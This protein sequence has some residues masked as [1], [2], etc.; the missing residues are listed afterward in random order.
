MVRVLYILILALY[1]LIIAGYIFR[2]EISYRI[3]N[4][5]PKTVEKRDLTYEEYKALQNSISIRET[6]SILVLV[7][8][9]V[10]ALFSLVILYYKPFAPVGL[11]KIALVVSVLFGFVLFVLRGI[12][13]V[14]IPPIR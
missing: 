4:V 3:I 14:P 10:V 2:Y 7:S 9:V 12:G 6:F 8:S 13:F 5:N 1:F 11:V